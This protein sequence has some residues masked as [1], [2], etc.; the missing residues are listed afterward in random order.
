MADNFSQSPASS[1]APSRVLFFA[2]YGSWVGHNIFDA[3]TALALRL[4]GAEACVVGCDGVFQRSCYV[5][6]HSSNPVPDCAQCA[7]SGQSLFSKFKLPLLQIRN[8]LRQEDVSEVEKWAYSVTDSTF[9][10][11]KFEGLE[12]GE[13]VT[14]IICSY[15]RTSANQLAR[16]HIRDVH[17][18]YAGYAVLGYRALS[19]IFDEW[20]PTCLVLTNG[21]GFIHPSAVHVAKAKGIPFVTHETGWGRGTYFLTSNVFSGAIAPQAE[22]IN[23]WKDVPLKTESLNK[24]KEYFGGRESGKTHNWQPFYEFTTD[25][26]A[27]RA[28]LAIPMDA[29]ILAVLTSSECEIT[30]NFEYNSLPPQHDAIDRLIEIFRD[31][32]EYL[33][34]R[35]HPKIG[36]NKIGLPDY[37]FLDRVY[38]QAAKAPPNV[39][40]ITPDEELTSYALF[41]SSDAAIAFYSTAGVEA[42]AC[43]LPVAAF[44]PVIFSHC[45]TH[46]F[47]TAEPAALRA[48]IDSLFEKTNHVSLE[49]LRRFYRSWNA[50]AYRYSNTFK[51][52]SATGGGEVTLNFTDARQLSPGADP[53]LDRLC[54]HILKRTPVYDFPLGDSDGGTKD[55]ETQFL[56]AELSSLRETRTRVKAAS[57]EFFGK[58]PP[59]IEVCGLVERGSLAQEIVKVRKRQHG[60]TEIKEIEANRPPVERVRALR[61]ALD[62]TRAPYVMFGEK[63]VQPDEAMVHSALERLQKNPTLPG[64]LSGV[65][66]ADASGNLRSHLLTQKQKLQPIEKVAPELSGIYSPTALLSAVVARREAWIKMLDT[67]IQLNEEPTWQHVWRVVTESGFEQSGL[68]MCVVYPNTFT[69]R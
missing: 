21:Q 11:A 31:R 3:V 59:Q 39:R 37:E 10:G 15:F 29:K 66:L 33:V 64:I 54:N 4:R 36:A 62:N 19:R 58:L 68:A 16:P 22:V 46:S 38:K 55:A 30:H 18:R 61:S 20:K 63:N 49:D 60:V 12:V 25:H 43:G 51:T 27:V 35:H 41:W 8:Y 24:I 6:A 1:S 34:I 56:E 2:P 47:E 26:A 32:P 65:W 9:R 53:T 45:V 52:F 40:I 13:W 28:K 67:L 17:R 50:F 5:L 7:A 57:S 42:S 69:G 44:T 14:P 23:A 48:L